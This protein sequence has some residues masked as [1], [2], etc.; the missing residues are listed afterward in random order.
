MCI[1]A[2]YTHV[3]SSRLL[4]VNVRAEASDPLIWV[5]G[6]AMSVPFQN[7]IQ[8]PAIAFGI[9]FPQLAYLF[10]LETSADYSKEDIKNDQLKHEKMLNIINN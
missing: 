2:V 1:A 10:V 6:Y 4:Q 8:D 9:K 5:R 3:Y 7:F